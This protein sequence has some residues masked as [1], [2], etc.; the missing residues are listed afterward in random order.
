MHLFSCKLVLFSAE[1]KSEERTS[2]GIAVV[3]LPFEE[4]AEEAAHTAGCGSGN[5]AENSSEKTGRSRGVEIERAM[6]SL[7]CACR[8]GQR[9]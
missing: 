6:L 2:V 1:K 8:R 5:I 3:V 9:A 7:T 4:G